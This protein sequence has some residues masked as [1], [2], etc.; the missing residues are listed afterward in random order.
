MNARA[1][2]VLLLVTG[3]LAVAAALVYT[4]S[5]PGST[6]S[7]RDRFLPDL[8]DRIN[9]VAQVEIVDASRRTH[10]V[11]E[12]DRWVL[13]EKTGIAALDNKVRPLLIKLAEAE[14]VEPK[15]SNPD[16]YERIGVEDV[17]EASTSTQLT[18]SDAD[19]NTI[20]SVI[21]GNSE[22]R[23][24]TQLRYARRVG[25]PQ[26]Y[27]IDFSGDASSD[28]LNWIDKTLV[29]VDGS[30]VQSVMITH[31][32]GEEMGL[33]KATPEQEHFDVAPIPEGREL[34]SPGVADPISRALTQLNF[35]DVRPST[36]TSEGIETVVVYQ[37]FDGLVITLR[38]ADEAGEKWAILTAESAGQVEDPDELARLQERFA[39]RAFKL[40]AWAAN[41][42]SK[43]VTDVL[44]PLEEPR[45]I[46]ALED[47]PLGPVL[48]PGG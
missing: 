33:S 26:S 35:E 31:P 12:D 38:I 3:V 20:A 37:T 24:T 30:R 2:L 18:C 27:L 23:G 8:M 34:R 1:V 15:T 25:Q 28:P 40:P 43:R 21:L 16:L 4:R 6:S 10:I 13:P 9:E 22:R 11:R 44:A 42:M 14:I 45:E 39:G 5:N 48:D 41:N 47:P 7:A 29:K 17:G 46:P 19:G 36:G 32:T